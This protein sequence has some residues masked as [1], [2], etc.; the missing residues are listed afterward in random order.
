MSLVLSQKPLA[1]DKCLPSN[2]V[3]ASKGGICQVDNFLLAKTLASS[4]VCP[5]SNSL[6]PTS[7]PASVVLAG[8]TKAR[9]ANE[10]V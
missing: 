6:T 9:E 10:R 2:E 8:E 1:E 4:V 5:R 3:K 7:P